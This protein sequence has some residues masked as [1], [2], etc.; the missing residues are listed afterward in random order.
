MSLPDGRIA[1]FPASPA[2]VRRLGVERR[3]LGV[4][5]ARCSFRAPE[6][7]FVSGYD[8]AGIEPRSQLPGE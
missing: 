4:L 7:L 6:V 5:A 2:G 1:W 8:F 3:V